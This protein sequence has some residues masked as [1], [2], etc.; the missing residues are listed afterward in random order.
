MDKYRLRGIKVQNISLLKHLAVWIASKE[1]LEL[2]KLLQVTCRLSC[3]AGV[4]F[5]FSHS[6]SFRN[7]LLHEIF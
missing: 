7:L 5:M 1:I 3:I 4:P 6:F 2:G